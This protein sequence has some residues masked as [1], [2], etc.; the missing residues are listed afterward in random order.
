[1]ELGMN[2]VLSKERGVIAVEWAIEKEFID[3]TF[4]LSLFNRICNVV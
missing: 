2:V 1:M 3:E 4:K